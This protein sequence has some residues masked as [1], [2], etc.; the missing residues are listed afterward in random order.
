[1]TSDLPRIPLELVGMVMDNIPAPYPDVFKRPLHVR[2][3]EQ[4][5]VIHGFLEIV[6]THALQEGMKIGLSI[7]SETKYMVVTAEQMEKIQN[8]M[9][10]KETGDA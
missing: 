2:R 4:E 7:A 6:W 8:D 5:Q 9:K 10:I 1:M 3:M